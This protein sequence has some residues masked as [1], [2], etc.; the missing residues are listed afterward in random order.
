MYPQPIV[1][2]NGQNISKEET[3]KLNEKLKTGSGFEESMAG[4]RNVNERIKLIYGKKY[5][6]KASR[7]KPDAESDSDQTEGV[8][9]VLIFP[10]RNLI[11]SEEKK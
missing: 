9:V 8:C 10:C 2:N 11:R 4:L 6:V 7:L 5:G 3:K 1:E